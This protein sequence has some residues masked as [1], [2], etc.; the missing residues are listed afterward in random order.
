MVLDDKA[1]DW[2]VL[3][4]NRYLH[5]VAVDT[6]VRPHAGNLC[7]RK[8]HCLNDL[9]TLDRNLFGING[10]RDREVGIF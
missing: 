6:A 10:R 2:G 3:H 4:V 7:A 5:Y 1:V 9:N 8:L